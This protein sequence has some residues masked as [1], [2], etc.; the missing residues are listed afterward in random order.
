MPR[1]NRFAFDFSYSSFLDDFLKGNY[2]EYIIDIIKN[3]VNGYQTVTL[4]LFEGMD[5]ERAISVY[6]FLF[7]YKKILHLDD[8]ILE[9]VR[10]II[11]EKYKNIEIVEI[12]PS[13]FDLFENNIY[14]LELEEEIYFVPLWHNEMVFESKIGK[15]IIVK[16]VPELPENIS[17]DENNNIIVEI[18]VLFSF[19]LVV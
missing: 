1:L 18:E 5:K 15:E 3:I 8:S 14:K 16:C 19:S 13:L 7:Q 17:I 6:D 11:A 12:N 2:N 10:E 9:K 4:K